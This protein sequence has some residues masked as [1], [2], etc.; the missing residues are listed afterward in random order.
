M[1]AGAQIVAILLATETLPDPGGVL[2]RYPSTGAFMLTLS[3][4]TGISAVTILLALIVPGQGT[5]A[6][7]AL[8][9][10]RS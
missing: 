4:I 6:E 2:G 3:V 10:K 7:P 8:A 1:A 9:L 5:R